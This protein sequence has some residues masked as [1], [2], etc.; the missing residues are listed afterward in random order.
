MKS[1]RKLICVVLA[2]LIIT[3]ACGCELLALN[4]EKDLSSVVATVA[5]KDYTK[6]EFLD[7]FN[8]ASIL[9]ETNGYTV[10]SEG[11]A[12]KEYKAG[13][14]RQF[15]EY[16]A[17]MAYCEE[18]GI[19][20]EH[21]VAEEK[22]EF[23]EFLK[24]S[25]DDAAYS[26]LISKYGYDEESFGAA[27]DAYIEMALAQEAFYGDGVDHSDVFDGVSAF[28]VDGTEVGQKELYYYAV[29]MMF[30]N[31]LQYQ[32]FPQSDDDVKSFFKT[33]KDV[34]YGYYYSIYNYGVSQGL[35]LTDEEIA[36]A[37]TTFDIL[38]DYLGEDLL[39]SYYTQYFLSDEDVEAARLQTGRLLAMY[40]K[41]STLFES[42]M[43]PSEEDVKTY[44]EANL[45]Q[46]EEQIS[47]YHILT[48]DEKRAEELLKESKGTPEGFMAIFEKY[49]AGTDQTIR[50][51][52]D[53]GSFNYAKMV[54]EF[55]EPVFAMEVGEVKGMIKTEFG[56][57]L[58]YVYDKTPA[59]TIE[60]DYD[61]IKAKYIEANKSQYVYDRM[62]EITGDAKIK[63]GSFDTLPDEL[64][65]AMLEKTYGIKIHENVA[66]R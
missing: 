52:A 57:H 13:L 18:K 49:S 25:Y 12:L 30:Y 58:V 61:A 63:D 64:A 9:S 62:E 66:V 27:L 50:E 65:F 28:T 53:L 55:S 40:E 4:S 35:T 48:E 38:K 22:E 43:D 20:A 45:T 10:P 29:N 2:A 15:A 16:K 56:Y 26:A 39:K 21:T 42:E 41:V 5:G 31:Y 44:Y 37:S 33:V 3:G 59:Q 51:A 24:N 60:N 14:L 54:P 34:Y 36:D 8:I 11:D 7:F 17:M 47:A 19:T 46:F 6:K 32:S 1:F 23:M